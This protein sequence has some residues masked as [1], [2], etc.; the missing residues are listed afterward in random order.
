[1]LLLF[2]N[3]RAAASGLLEIAAAP[4]GPAPAPRARRLEH[5]QPSL[6]VGAA[7]RPQLRCA[8][9]SVVL[10]CGGEARKLGL[11]RGLLPGPSVVSVA[12]VRW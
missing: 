1:M 12:S 5:H 9:S 8:L 2:V 3:L 11:S 6:S 7:S 4:R 10:S